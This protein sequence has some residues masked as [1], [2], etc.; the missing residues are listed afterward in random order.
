MPQII[1]AED[2]KE[3]KKIHNLFRKICK[4][5]ISLNFIEA[6]YS[7]LFSNAWR[8]IKFA[9]SNEFFMI[10]NKKGFD[11]NKVYNAIKLNYPR[12]HDLPNS[13]FAAGPCLPKDAIQL[14][15][16]CKSHSDLVYGS[17]KINQY[18]PKFLVSNL[19]KTNKVQNKYVGILG[20]TFKGEIDD[21]RDSLSLD[22]KKELIKLK[23][24][25]I[26]YDPFIN[27]NIIN[28]K[29]YLKMPNNFYW[30]SS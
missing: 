28:L 22:L 21:E 5:T 12:N 6:E 1:S 16:S 18:L 15:N 24:K 7:K 25:V 10:S 20:T 14:W 9:A 4:K 8:Y 26:T 3:E 17:Y 11:Y 19:N 27:K 29:K 13:G 2:K 30:N 23:A